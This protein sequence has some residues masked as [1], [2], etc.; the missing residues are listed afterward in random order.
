MILLD[1]KKAYNWL[2]EARYD[3]RN[4]EN[5]YSE[6]NFKIAGWHMYMTPE[7]SFLWA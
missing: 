2:K 7:T 5:A 4:L 3:G 1:S 6:D